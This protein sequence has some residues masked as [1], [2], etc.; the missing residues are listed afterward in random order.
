MQV[1]K[2]ATLSSAVLAL[3]AC[4]DYV[5][6]PPNYIGLMLTPTGYDNSIYTPGQVDIGV[7]SS[8][9]RG[10]RLVLIQRSGFAVKEQ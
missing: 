4:Q 3:A 8:T 2:I 9:N 5:S 6:V 10:N 1:I 7:E